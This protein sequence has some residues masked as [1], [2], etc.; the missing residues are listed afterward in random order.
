MFILYTY[1]EV[2]RIIYEAKYSGG[3]VMVRR[4]RI[5]LIRIIYLYNGNERHIENS[6]D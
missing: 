5:Y 4:S 6:R 1:V 2:K 3:F